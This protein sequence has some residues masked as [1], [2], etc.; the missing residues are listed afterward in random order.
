MQGRR[1]S[2]PHRRHPIAV[3]IVQE[4]KIA[5][6]VLVVIWTWILH[7][8]SRLGVRRRR[9]HFGPFWILGDDDDDEGFGRTGVLLK[10]IAC[11]ARE[12]RM[13]SIYLGPAS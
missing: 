11:C 6:T 13:F 5:R 7:D 4:G 12:K 8:G 2:R 1:L 10:A 3:N 9:R